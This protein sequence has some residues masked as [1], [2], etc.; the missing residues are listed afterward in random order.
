MNSNTILKKLIG[1]LSTNKKILGSIAKLSNN[2][3][4]NSAQVTSNTPARAVSSFGRFFPKLIL[5]SFLVLI[6]IF[7]GIDLIWSIYSFIL[8]WLSL[9]ENLIGKLGVY[10]GTNLTTLFLFIFLITYIFSDPTSEILQK[11][12]KWFIIFLILIIVTSLILTS[13]L[14]TLYS[15]GE[16]VNIVQKKSISQWDSFVNKLTCMGSPSCIQADLKKNEAVDSKIS[17]YSLYFDKNSLS[18]F[19]YTPADLKNPLVL[20]YKIRSSGDLVLNKIDCYLD[21]KNSKAFYSEEKNQIIKTGSSDIYLDNFKCDNIYDAISNV[22]KTKTKAHTV[23]VVLDFSFETLYTQAIPIIDY[24]NFLESQNL[25]PQKTYSY[26]YLKERLDK[27]TRSEKS[28][29]QSNDALKVDDNIITDKLPLLLGDGDDRFISFPLTISINKAN[30]FGSFKSGEILDI[31]LPS[32]LKFKNTEN[33]YKKEINVIND[34]FTQR[35]NLDENEAGL[36]TSLQVLTK[37]SLSI[38][39]KSNFEREDRFKIKVVDWNVINSS[40]SINNTN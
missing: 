29:I 5:I 24:K 28:F 17:D 16:Q 22:Q 13:D 32:S 11:E 21:D 12:F 38:K 1:S 9:V 35:I 3:S 15:P 4:I 23:I 39:I 27:K 2:A 34:K 18:N 20:D 25:N 37:Q 10:W 14:A 19:E 8:S 31:S 26:N 6:G 33:N 30:D 40:T 7:F 36:D